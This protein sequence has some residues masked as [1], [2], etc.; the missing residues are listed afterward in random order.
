MDLSGKEFRWEM[1][2]SDIG[3][4]VG[5]EVEE[6]ADEKTAAETGIEETEEKTVEAWDSSPES[7][8]AACPSENAIQGEFLL[9]RRR[10]RLCWQ[11]M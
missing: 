3:V 5:G 9:H 4:G 11:R 7:A 10:Q 1:G 8:T 2:G 6:T